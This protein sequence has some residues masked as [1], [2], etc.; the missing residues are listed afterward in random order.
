MEQKGNFL[1][2]VILVSIGMPA[3]GRIIRG[4][5]PISMIYLQPE[6]MRKVISFVYENDQPGEIFNR[7]SRKKIAEIYKI[8]LKRD[9]KKK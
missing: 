9:G 6:N 1:F 4:F 8:I 3:G 7:N 5:E 2:L